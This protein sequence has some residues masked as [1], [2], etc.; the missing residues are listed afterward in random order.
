MLIRMNCCDFS[1]NQKMSRR[2]SESLLKDIIRDINKTVEELQKKDILR[3][4]RGVTEKQTGP[5]AYEI[6]FSGKSDASSIMLDKHVSA[7]YVMDTLLKERQ[8]SILLYDKGIIQ[9]E[10]CID[11]GEITKERLVFLKKHN[12]IWDKE[13]IFAA[14]A[15]DEDW[16][17]GEESVP[18]FLRIDFDPSCHVECDH[19]ISHL[20]LGNNESCRIPIQNAV[21]FSEFLR[22]VLLHFYAIKLETEPYCIKEETT[23]TELEKKMFH[24]G[25]EK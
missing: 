11:D 19:P 23:I 17:A 12:R 16:F 21:S 14:D 24:L 4:T 6:S 18:T 10:F 7:T 3:D 15:Q 22:F 13:E 2:K 25:W 5:N 9:A 20:T 1:K 8:Y